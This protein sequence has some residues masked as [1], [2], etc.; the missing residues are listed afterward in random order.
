MSPHNTDGVKKHYVPASMFF[1]SNILSSSL[2]DTEENEENDAE[3][4]KTHAQITD[5]K[6]IKSYTYLMDRYK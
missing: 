4:D 5:M 1:S 2:Y 3:F 6:D